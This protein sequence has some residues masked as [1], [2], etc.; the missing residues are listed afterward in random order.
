MRLV[1]HGTKRSYQ[2]AKGDITKSKILPAIIAAIKN[3][4]FRIEEMEQRKS[5]LSND[6]E[7][8]IKI[9]EKGY[10][11]EIIK[12][13]ERRKLQLMKEFE[14]FDKKQAA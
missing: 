14:A 10:D 9:S 11:L 7:S 1:S 5:S 13:L 6:I 3:L 8:L 12:N 2:I 4:P